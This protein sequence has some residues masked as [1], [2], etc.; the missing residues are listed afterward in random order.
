MSEYRQ[1]EFP[2]VTTGGSRRDE[3][4]VYEYGEYEPWS[5]LAG[6]ERRSFIDSYETLKEARLNHPE[7][8]TDGGNAFPPNAIGPLYIPRDPPEWFDPMDA[9]EA[10]GEDDY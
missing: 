6:Q 4:A 8:D 7:A 5:V 10:W 1:I 2:A 9:G 3:Y